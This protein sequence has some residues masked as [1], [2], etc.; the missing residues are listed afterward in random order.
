[1]EHD[2]AG[3]L[4]SSMQSYLTT[5]PNETVTKQPKSNL[6]SEL[7]K[8]VADGK[9]KQ[10]VFHNLARLHVDNSRA[11]KHTAGP[12]NQT[13]TNIDPLREEKRR[14]AEAWYQE[15]TRKKRLETAEKER[16]LFNL[17]FEEVAKVRNIA[18]PADFLSLSF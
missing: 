1:M 4:R 16:K 10:S 12:I 8:L 9:V 18:L 14:Q 15:Q 3:A 5:L 17:A 6:W 7:Q 2:L 11:G 13:Y